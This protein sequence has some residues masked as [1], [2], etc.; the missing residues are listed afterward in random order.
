MM[1]NRIT[2]KNALKAEFSQQ[3][4][5]VFVLALEQGQECNSEEGIIQT[6]THGMGYGK[7]PIRKKITNTITE[8]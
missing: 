3:E 6:A 8:N 1:K 4:P 5:R 2:K 7:G